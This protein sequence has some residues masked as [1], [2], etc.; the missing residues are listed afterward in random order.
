MDFLQV[1]LLAFVQ[2]VTEFLPVSSSAHLVVVPVLLDWQDQGVVF[3]IAVHVGTLLAVILYF[4]RQVLGLLR[5]AQHTLCGRWHSEEARLVRALALSAVP[6]VLLALL[7]AGWAS[8]TARSVPLLAITSIGFGLLLGW[9]DKR[10]VHPHKRQVSIQDALIFG[11]FQALAI[12]PG[13]SRSGACLTAGRLLGYNREVAGRF[14]TLMA[15]PVIVMAGGY[16]LFK[17]G[18]AG[19]NWAVDAQVLL[20]GLGAAFLFALGGIHLL[21]TWL[22]RTGY[23][24]FVVYRVVLGVGLLVWFYA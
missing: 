15:L 17:T 23:W 13:T 6:L 19:V 18:V 2:G 9:A 22:A 5:G 16:S 7:L 21:M 3:D 24:P 8:S 11:C 10:P 1:F 12:V 14:G 4:W 20:L